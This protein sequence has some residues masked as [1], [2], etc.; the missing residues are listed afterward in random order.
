MG[1]CIPQSFLERKCTCSPSGKWDASLSH[2]TKP[3]HPGEWIRT[4][5]EGRAHLQDHIHKEGDTVLH[6]HWKEGIQLRKK[7]Q[8]SDVLR[9][10]WRRL[11][12]AA[13]GG[14]CELQTD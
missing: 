2:E 9:E 1:L 4:A 11:I 7:K 6:L 10:A 12:T 14:F 8:Q 5:R 3:F 13:A